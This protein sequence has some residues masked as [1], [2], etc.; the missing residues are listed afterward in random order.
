MKRLVNIFIA[1]LLSLMIVWMGVGVA[2]VH[3]AHSGRYMF[4]EQT[5]HSS[6]CETPMKEKCMKVEVHK[7]STQAQAHSVVVDLQPVFSF[8]AVLPENQRVVPQFLEPAFLSPRIYAWHSPP[9]D[10]LSFI[11]ILQL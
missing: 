8:V 10:Y 5:S 6:H 7:L 1:S 2:V 11:R 4:T 9:R 3:C